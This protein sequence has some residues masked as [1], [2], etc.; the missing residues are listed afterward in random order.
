MSRIA[1][2]DKEL[3]LVIN[4]HAVAVAN[5]NRDAKAQNQ[6]EMV[7]NRYYPEME[8]DTRNR[9]E[10]TKEGSRLGLATPDFSGT[11]N[12]NMYNYGNAEE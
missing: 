11:G 12:S 9:R 3:P 2:K 1:A 8:K 6:F 7:K 4:P 5:A 10:K